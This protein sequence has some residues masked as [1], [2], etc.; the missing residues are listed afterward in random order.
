M[1]ELITDKQ[2]ETCEKLGIPY[3]DKWTKKG[4]WVVMSSYI[5]A[6]NEAPQNAEK[7]NEILDNIKNDVMRFHDRH[8]PLFDDGGDYSELKEY[9][10][11]ILE[12]IERYKKYD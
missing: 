7:L 2:K 12:I 11:S 10:D 3:T 9:T 1:V 6:M 8:I 5:N 4:A